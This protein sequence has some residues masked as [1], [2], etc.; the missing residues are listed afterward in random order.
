MTPC[1]ETRLAA[2]GSVSTALA[3]LSDHALRRELDA[4]IPLGSGIGGKAV[5]MEVAGRQ[6]FVKRVPLTARELRPENI[7][8]T[9]DLFDLPMYC[10]YGIGGPAFGAWRELAAHVMTTNW[11]L[12]GGFA[13]FPL[14]YHWRVLPDTASL[15]EELAD[16]DRV[17]DY[18][19]GGDQVRRRLEEQRAS[20]ASIAL[21]LEYLPHNLFDWL[22]EQLRAGGEVAERALAMADREL[23]A[24]IAFMNAHGLLHFDAHFENVLTDGERLYYADFGLAIS[25]RFELAND[26]R[27]FFD[28]HRNYDRCYTA[29]YTGQWLVAELFGADRD[30]RAARLRAYAAGLVPS[31]IPETAAAILIRDAPVAV[32]MTEFFDLLRYETRRAVYPAG[33]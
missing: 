12:M 5:S 30:E 1:P 6:V 20:E 26:E 16:I 11:V 14:M 21:F 32:A 33:L 19:G 8:S 10:H 9:A 13:G 15:P 23:A 7:R 18:W 24:G 3:L 25:S 17:V 28:R 27:A 2:Y 4:S 22:R 29:M 31:G